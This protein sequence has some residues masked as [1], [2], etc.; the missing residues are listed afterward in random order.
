MCLDLLPTSD[1]LVAICRSNDFTAKASHWSKLVKAQ[2]LSLGLVEL[3]PG[4]MRIIYQTNK[5]EMMEIKTRHWKNFLEGFRSA[6][7]ERSASFVQH[8]FISGFSPP[9]QRH[10]PSLHSIYFVQ[11]RYKFVRVIKT[12]FNTFSE[13]RVVLIPIPV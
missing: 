3:D 11:Y 4:K 8:G 1:H 10:M 12:H 9:Q 13:N 5:V 6:D 2:P 7:S